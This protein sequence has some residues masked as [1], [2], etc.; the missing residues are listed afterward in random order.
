MEVNKWGNGKKKRAVV[1]VGKSWDLLTI[2]GTVLSG[3]TFFCKK[4]TKVYRKYEVL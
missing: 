2:Y 1:S 3:I 4:D